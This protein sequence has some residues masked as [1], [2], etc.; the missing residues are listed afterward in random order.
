MPFISTPVT[1]LA[2]VMAAILGALTVNS[3]MDEFRLTMV[4]RCDD[5]LSLF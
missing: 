5:F 1:I 2:A 3:W 4:G